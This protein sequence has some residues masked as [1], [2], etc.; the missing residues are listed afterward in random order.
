MPAC[1]AD[2]EEAEGAAGGPLPLRNSEWIG[3]LLTLTATNTFHASNGTALPYRLFR[4][5]VAAND[6]LPLVLCLHAAGT[7]G[8]DNRANLRG[9]QAFLFLA[10]EELQRKFPCFLVAP[11]CPDGKR[12]VA[13]PW[14]KGTYSV[15][16][17]PMSAE[18]TCADEL[19]DSLCRT[20]PIDTNRVYVVGQSMGGFGAFDLL[21][22]R[23]GKFAAGLVSCGAAD[24][25][26]TSILK[27]VPLW[28]FHGEDD[29]TVPFAASRDLDA[30]LRAAG[31]K[32]YRFTS[33]PGVGHGSYVNTF[34]TDGV[35][36]WLFSQR[37]GL[38]AK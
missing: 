34:E 16:A 18:L 12:W 7:R 3:K 28:F 20:E 26:K 8:S 24:P 6:R 35:A 31:A 19:V 17:I 21:M 25:S 38:D 33:F 15:D 32:E 9:S 23:P 29:T 1:A 36:D 5:T 2:E 11:Q 27:E 13:T 14:K 10:Q 37:R 4:P 30:A 22:R